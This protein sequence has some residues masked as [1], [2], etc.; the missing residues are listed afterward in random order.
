METGVALDDVHRVDAEAE[1]PSEELRVRHAETGRGGV[2]LLQDLL[3]HDHVLL[4]LT[5]RQHASPTR[6]SCR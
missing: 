5:P 2:D 6:S 1:E 3:L 4:R